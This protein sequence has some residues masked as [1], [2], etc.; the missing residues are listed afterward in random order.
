MPAGEAPRRRRDEGSS[1]LEARRAGGGPFGFPDGPSSAREEEDMTY[2][3]GLRC[4]VCDA[5]Y[6]AEAR[7]ICDECFGPVEPLYDEDRIRAEVPRESIEG[8][9]PTLWRVPPPLLGDAS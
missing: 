8:G 6:P 9:P 1:G 4:R 7:S 2:L 5:R 3:E